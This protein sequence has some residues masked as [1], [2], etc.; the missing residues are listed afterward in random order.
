MGFMAGEWLTQYIVQP[1]L[2]HGILHRWEYFILKTDM[3]QMCINYALEHAF[4]SKRA[5]L[6]N[7]ARTATEYFC[8]QGL[9][10]ASQ[11]H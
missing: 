9:E 5:A 1:F 7:V 3:V 6:Q 10:M 2:L 4:Y 11:N 8:D